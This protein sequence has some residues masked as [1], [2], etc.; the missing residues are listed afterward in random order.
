LI[1]CVLHDPSMATLPVHS[2]PAQLLKSKEH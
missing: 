1:F 2:R